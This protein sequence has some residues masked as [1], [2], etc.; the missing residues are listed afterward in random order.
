MP[1]VMRRDSSASMT[2]VKPPRPGVELAAAWPNAAPG[3]SAAPGTG[4]KAGHAATNSRPQLHAFRLRALLAGPSEMGERASQK[5]VRWRLWQCVVRATDWRALFGAGDVVNYRVRPTDH[6][7]YRLFDR[8]IEVVRL[9][10]QQDR[11][12]IYRTADGQRPPSR[13]TPRG[14][15]HMRFSRPRVTVVRCHCRALHVTGAALVVLT[16]A[17]LLALRAPLLRLQQDASST[18]ASRLPALAGERWS[19]EVPVCEP[20]AQSP[21]TWSALASGRPPASVPSAKALTEAELSAKP[22]DWRSVRTPSRHSRR[23][24]AALTA[25][26][27]IVLAAAPATAKA[28]ATDLLLLAGSPVSLPERTFGQGFT[29]PMS[30]RSWTPW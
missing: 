30:E 3:S 25:S 1:A 2:H 21:R 5:R 27:V 6:L 4:L 13:P 7:A 19:D 22:R 10:R 9:G 28:A 14:P 26:G 15:R 12:R 23:A 18:H 29:D 20:L 24:A 8:A 11:V 17:G 16:R